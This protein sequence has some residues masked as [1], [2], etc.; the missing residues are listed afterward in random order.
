MPT[1]TVRK[2]SKVVVALLSNDHFLTEERAKA[3]QIKDRMANVIG[4]SVYYGSFSNDGSGNA[5][6]AGKK[7]T[8]E[9][10]SS[11]SFN[12]SGS[13]GSG[14]N[15]GASMSFGESVMRTLQQARKTEEPTE[16]EESSPPQ[17]EKP[18]SKL[19]LS[20]MN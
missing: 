1:Y 10:F 19:N 11:S 7:E 8:Y 18:S 17:A 6:A 16:K 12:K 15:S 4:S 14:Y 3:K 13:L 2:Q 5:P 9:S 20:K